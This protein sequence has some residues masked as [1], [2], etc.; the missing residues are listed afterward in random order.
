M[1]DHHDTDYR[2]LTAHNATIYV[3]LFHALIKNLSQLTMRPF[4]YFDVLIETCDSSQWD[5]LYIFDALI[6]TSD[7]SQ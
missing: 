5:Y 3:T 2:N 7:N 6:E 4:I 1:T